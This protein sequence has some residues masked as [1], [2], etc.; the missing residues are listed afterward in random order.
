M[1]NFLNKCAFVALVGWFVSMPVCASFFGDDDDT[2]S[3]SVT[4]PTDPKSATKPKSAAEM[5]GTVI[6]YDNREEHWSMGNPVKP[7][8]GQSN[9]DVMKRIFAFYNVKTGKFLSLGGWWGMRTVLSSSPYLFWLQRHNNDKVTTN[10]DV[11]YPLHE[12]ETT[13]VPSLMEHMFDVHRDRTCQIG[14]GSQQGDESFATYNKLQVVNTGTGTGTGTGTSAGTTTTTVAYTVDPTKD[15]TGHFGTYYAIDLTKQR[16]EAEIDLSTSKNNNENI[17]SIGSDIAHWGWGD[18]EKH[19]VA[20]NIHIYYNATDKA[21]K[22]LDAHE[23]QVVYLGTRCNDANGEKMSFYNVNPL[24]PLKLA[25]TSKGLEVNVVASTSHFADVASTLSADGKIQVGSLEGDVRSNAT[26]KQLQI[27]HGDGTVE[28]IV[29]DGYKPN[30]TVIGLAEGA[31]YE[32]ETDCGANHTFDIDK[33]K[34]VAAIDLTTCQ[35]DKENILSIGRAVGKWLGYNL[36]FY[37]SPSTG[38]LEMDYTTADRFYTTG[39]KTIPLADKTEPLRITMSKEGVVVHNGSTNTTTLFTHESASIGYCEGNAIEVGSKQGVNRSHATYKKVTIGDEDVTSTFNSQKTAGFVISKVIDINNDKVVADIDLS[40]CTGT[41][42][43]L[44]SLGQQIDQWKVGSWGSDRQDSTGRIHLYYTPKTSETGE[45][46]VWY[47]GRGQQESFVRSVASNT[48]LHVE[49]SKATGLTIN[50]MEYFVKLEIPYR[51]GYEGEVV[52][53]KNVKNNVPE[54]DDKGHYIQDDS[55]SRIKRIY[56]NYIFADESR[57]NKRQTYFVSS[58]FAKSAKYSYTEG[59]FF[60]YTNLQS[61]NGDYNSGVYGDRAIIQMSG[62]NSPQVSQWSFNPVDDPSGKGQNLYTL[63]LSMPY[64]AETTTGASIAQKQFFLAPTQKYVYGPEGNKY[65]DS[66]TDETGSFDNANELQDVELTSTL[67]DNCYWKVISLY[68]YRQIMDNSDSELRHQIDA[69]FL[70]SDPNFS[71]E[72]KVLNMWQSTVDS[73]HLRIG[74]DGYYKTTTQQ[75]DYMESSSGWD[76]RYNHA[77][78]MA[79]NI[80]NGGRGRVSQTLKV[81][82]PGWYVIRCKGM[83]NV[84]AKLFI[85]H[86]GRRNTKTLAQVTST[87]L[88]TLR[89]TDTSVAKWP[90]DPGMPIYNSS[91]WMNDPYR[92]NADPE[93]YDNQVLLYIDD[94]SYEN[95]GDVTIGVELTDDDV[96]ATGNQVDKEDEWTVFDDFRILFGGIS[97]AK[98]SFL[99]LDEDKTSLDYLD[100]GLHTYKGKSLLLHRSFS[101]N[102]WN[103]FIMPVSLTKAQFCG[104]FGKDSRLANLYDLTPIR[105][106]FKSV[107]IRNV[108]DDDIVLEAGKPYIIKPTKAAGNTD[109]SLATQKIWTWASDGDE[110]KEVTVGTPFYTILGVTLDGPMKTDNEIE[111]YNFTTLTNYYDDNIYVKAS[112]GVNGDGRGTMAMKG[113][114]C[115]NFSGTSINEGHA[116]LNVTGNTY[117]YVMKDNTMRALPQGQPYGTKGLRCWFE[118][119]LDNTQAKVTPKVYI[120]GV[121]DEVTSVDIVDNDGQQTIG[122][123]YATGVYNLNGQQVRQDASTTGLPSGLYIVNGKKV[124]VKN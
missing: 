34:V 23:L 7:V 12:G 24:S 108:G 44:L 62:M 95:Q 107:D 40:T 121:G 116:S 47:V 87:D 30:G 66:D 94:V 29:A 22:S 96:A 28:K 46:I 80:Y 35:K 70:I 59:N 86:N 82:T 26:Y 10:N 76:K 120:D 73:D 122:G 14:I 65:Y 15:A 6:S 54:V 37:Y 3:G 17:L 45:L 113:T 58:S 16:V 111:H 60:A 97:P 63:S 88:Q 11:R 43:N 110:Y 74:F 91:V 1:K 124:I 61:E 100:M 55:G 9:D 49:F 119:T 92:K 33:D 69:T 72:N 114:Y 123:R 18:K 50:G 39:R 104:A 99:I 32:K 102:K 2:G 115:K 79:A 51:E 42:E 93:K 68:D 71:R 84:G 105:V 77:R 81:F 13:V 112:D 118:Y 67:T 38:S 89:S 78:Y 75:V 25:L 27:E 4:T 56:N 31:T 85:E 109:A 48:T 20:D 103:T 101:L 41:N 5:P 117:A 57:S 36:H 98:E 53:Y 64:D 83:S 19:A 21:T 8:E 106:N 90:M 52:R